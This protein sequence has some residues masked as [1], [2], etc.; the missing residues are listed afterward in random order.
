M[1]NVILVLLSVSSGY[2]FLIHIRSI[3]VTKKAPVFLMQHE[4]SV[5]YMSES[6][7]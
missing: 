1:E 5:N 7:L 4:I 3:T 2:E 6:V